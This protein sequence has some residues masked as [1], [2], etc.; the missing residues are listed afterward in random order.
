[1]SDKQKLI[2]TKEQWQERKPIRHDLFVAT[3]RE[4]LLYLSRW[5][6]NLADKTIIGD[7]LEP[8]HG[9]VYESPKL[10]VELIEELYVPMEDLE[11]Y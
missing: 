1:M 6:K 3:D 2:T 8:T 4:G 7:E 11:D 10:V 5:F 9:D